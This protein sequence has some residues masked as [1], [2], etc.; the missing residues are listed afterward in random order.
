MSVHYR[1]T[2]YSC[3]DVVCSVP[4]ETKRRRTQPR[5]VVQGFCSEIK[6]EG[7]KI[8]VK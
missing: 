5:L 8:Y 1:D 7:N 6:V 4:V 2:C 3:D